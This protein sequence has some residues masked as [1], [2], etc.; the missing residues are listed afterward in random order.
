MCVRDISELCVRKLQVAKWFVRA[1]CVV[2]VAPSLCPAQGATKLSL[3]VRSFVRVADPVIVLTHVRVI[4]GI[5]AATSQRSEG[6][7]RAQANCIYRELGKDL[8][9]DSR[10]SARHVCRRSG[11]GRNARAYVLSFGRPRGF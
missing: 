2:V 4:N 5:G 8:V 7:D 10:Q 9:A 1:V 6:S 3:E 11:F